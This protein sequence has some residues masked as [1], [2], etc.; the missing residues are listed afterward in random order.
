M[1][2]IDRDALTRALE[3]TRAEPDHTEQI[4]SMLKDRPWEEVTQFAA[5]HQQGK[6][7]RLKSGETPPCH[8]AV[9]TSAPGSAG[10]LSFPAANRLLQRVL[11]A[12]LSQW[13]PD[14]ES[15]LARGDGA[16][17]MQEEDA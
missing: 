3:L 10:D 16:Q 9:N 14:P 7:L 4:E 5:C 15:A 11:N 12:G 2:E 1:D 13:E 17:T 8:G 6:N